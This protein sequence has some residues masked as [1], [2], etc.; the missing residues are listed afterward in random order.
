MQRSIQGFGR[1]RDSVAQST[2]RHS[3]DGQ[4]GHDISGIVDTINLIA[5]RTNLLSLNASIEAARAGDAGRGFRGRGRGDPQPGRPVGQGDGRH[6]R[7]HQGAA[8]GRPGGRERVERGARGRSTRA[9]C[10]PR[11]ART[12]CE[13]SS[14]ASARRRRSSPRLPARRRAARRRQHVVTASP[15]PPSRPGR[16][17]R[18]PANRRKRSKGSSRRPRKCARSPRQVTKA[19]AEQGR[20]ARDIIKAAQ[21]E[22][23]GRQVRKA[24][25]EQAKTAAQITRGRR[26][27]ATGRGDH[28]ARGGGAGRRR[29]TDFAIGRRLR[30]MVAASPGHG[31]TGHG[32]GSRL[33][34]VREHED[35]GRHDPRAIQEQARTMK[36]M[37]AAAH[38]RRSRSS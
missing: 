33:P 35:A 29:R 8:G 36:E 14:T 6:R 30:L 2:T 32:D 15:P 11:K 7:H 19:M 3:R 13:R 34:R 25:A 18:P 12:V 31:R 5:E 16:S 17:R 9:T 20:A 27:D 10:R 26:G 1:V 28:G 37:T 22:G 21:D 38:T 24:T 4:A 23:L